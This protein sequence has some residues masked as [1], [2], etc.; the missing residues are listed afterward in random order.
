MI[1]TEED[2]EDILSEPQPETV[3]VMSRLDGDLMIL[4]CGGKMGPTLANMMVRAAA[5]AGVK[6]TVY[7]VSRFSNREIREK[8]EGW[9][10][11]CIP[12]DLLRWD[13]VER[14]P[15]V[16]NV[17]YL[18]GRKFGKVGSDYLYWA[19]N[20]IAPSH[21][22]RHFHDSRIVA[23]STGNVYNLWPSQ[24]DGPSEEDAFLSLG[25]YAN[26]CLG[27]ERI[28]EY[29]SRLNGTK[30]L[31]FR[32]NYAVELRYGVLYE[33]GK[34]LFEG[35]P[36]D[37]TTGYANVIWQGDANNIAVRCLEHVASPPEI[38]NVTGDKLRISEVA[39]MFG[40]RFSREPSFSG[41]EAPTALLSNS[42]K[43]KRLFG[44]P[45]TSLERMVEWI[46]EWIRRGGQSLDK[47][48]HFQTRDGRYLDD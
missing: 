1:E 31:L 39:R 34:S 12:C 16:R 21:A 24:S 22:A 35:K 36:I 40:E 11:A 19:M 13:E 6:K 4:G 32:L 14:L 10:I 7:G 2:L 17:L 47:P 3:A 26:S 44:A 15:R 25:E 46:A 43:M 5:R 37:L 41:A 27:R 33:I 9:G 29:Y 30:M 28:F 20:C 38:L 18:A 8:I 48:T 42:A 45:P 23:F